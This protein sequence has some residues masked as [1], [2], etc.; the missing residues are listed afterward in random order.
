MEERKFEEADIKADNAK[1]EENEY[2]DRKKQKTFYLG[3]K[4]LED[5]IA[6]SFL[7]DDDS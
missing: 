7:E 5:Q 6:C 1:E 3:L 4:N 2:E